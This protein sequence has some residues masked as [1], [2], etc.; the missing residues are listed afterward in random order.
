MSF[1]DNASDVKSAFY[2]ILPLFL[3][4]YK[5]ECFNANKL[6]ESLPSDVV[7]LLQEYEDVFPNNVPNGLSPISRASN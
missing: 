7:S 2:T 3:L 6:D 5:E 1:Y 4:L